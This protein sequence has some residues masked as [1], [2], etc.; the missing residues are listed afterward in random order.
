MA[1]RHRPASCDWAGTPRG[2]TGA[3]LVGDYRGTAAD[4]RPVSLTLTADGAYRSANLQIRDWYS[5]TWLPITATAT[6]RLDVDHRWYDRFTRTPPPAAVHL[7]DEY[8]SDF[9][10]GGTRA[11]PVLYDIL[12]HGD[13]CAQIHSLLRQT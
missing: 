12:D 5:G 1:R 10:V 8:A 7:T 6:W 13:S 4:G 3:D 9:A 11:D 2:V